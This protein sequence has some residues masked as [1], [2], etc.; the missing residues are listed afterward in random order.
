M[1]GH[2]E[3]I[4]PGQLPP[5]DS[6]SAS[7]A[8]SDSVDREGRRAVAV[9]TPDAVMISRAV[10]GWHAVVAGHGLVAARSL[11]ALDKRIRGLVGGGSVCYQFRIG[12]DLN[13]HGPPNRDGGVYFARSDRSTG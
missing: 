11:H 12:N 13:G 7:A 5:I 3:R 10:G 1:T 6:A 4:P 9:D 8:R 2:V